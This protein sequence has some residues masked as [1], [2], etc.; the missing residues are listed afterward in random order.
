MTDAL[1]K[2]EK[3]DVSNCK[4]DIAVSFA[5]KK[6]V[7]SPRV[8]IVFSSNGGNRRLPMEIITKN[9]KIFARGKYDAAFIFYDFTPSQIGISF[10]F[11]D[12]KDNGRKYN[13]D[14]TVNKIKKRAIRH[15]FSLTRHE[16]VKTLV[17]FILNILSFPFRLLSV[18]E[19]R[20]SF[21]TNR[22]DVPTGNLKAV[23]NTV[24]KIDGV[25]I[26]VICNSGGLRGI[27]EILFKFLYFYMT[28][29]I[30][31][32][33]DYYHLI[34]Y[35]KKKKKTT[36]IQLWHGCGAFKT[37]GFSR[38]HKSSALQLYSVNHRQYDYAIVSSP[39]ITDFYAEA[40]GISSEKVLP[41]GSPRCD[42]LTN[43]KYQKEVREKFYLEYPDL[44]NKKL[45]LFAPTFRGKGNGDCYYPVEKFN[46]DNVLQTLGEEWAVIIKLHP[47]LTEKLTF[48]RDNEKR[49]ADCGK[50]DINDILFV[51][52]FLVTDYSSVIFEASILEIPMAFLA[53]DLDK[54]I[55][56][57][58]FYYNFKYF[59]PGP[60]IKTD[61]EAAEIAKSG[62]YDL[63]KIKAF[64][65]KA[66]GNTM[67]NACSNIKALTLKLLER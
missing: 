1:M 35:V 17:G 26:H 15:F 14:L 9:G 61:V 60:I 57:R 25:D 49:V 23:Y 13:T 62:R 37:I 21:F 45:L 32:V 46:V 19:N 30:V 27:T 6:E 43:E 66:F 7:A 52:D 47:Y 31:Y 64:R 65:Q 63:E 48:S 24:K 20:I 58:D 18:K 34:S 42:I 2:I 50:W 10:V 8:S 40:F 38:F 11:S 5:P 55:A 39:E 16:K 33:D 51:T 12:G 36:L 29:K 4:I 67:G 59:V 54:F 22:T 53:F 28:S 3:F 44:I 41:L 56:K